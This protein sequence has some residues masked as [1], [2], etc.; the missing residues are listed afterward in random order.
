MVLG[1]NTSIRLLSG[2]KTPCARCELR[3]SVSVESS[4]SRFRMADTILR[5]NG[6]LKKSIADKE[7]STRR[8]DGRRRN[9]AATSAGKVVSIGASTSTRSV[10]PMASAR[11]FT[12]L[13]NRAKRCHFDRT[14]GTNTRRTWSG[15]A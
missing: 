3:S 6:L 9:L 7:A 14:G 5:M 8:T 4:T 11:I 13:G 12:Y 15:I 10:S 2:G 1:M